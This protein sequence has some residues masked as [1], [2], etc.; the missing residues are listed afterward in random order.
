MVVGA[1]I[2][3]SCLL[4]EREKAEETGEEAIHPSFENT[5]AMKQSE[6]KK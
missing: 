3:T 2:Y 1:F 6:L 4:I 5:G